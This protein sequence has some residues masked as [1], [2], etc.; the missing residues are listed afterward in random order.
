MQKGLI[1][2]FILIGILAVSL[3]GAGAY[4]YFY[5]HKQVAP[6]AG[7]YYREV[8]CIQAPCNPIL[9]CPQ[10]SPSPTQDETANWQTYTNNQ[11]GFSL[12][13]PA[14]WHVK[15]INDHPGAL[16]DLA[17]Y[18]NSDTGIRGGLFIGTH[19]EI[20]TY[21]KGLTLA[22]YIDQQIVKPYI[23]YSRS[24]DPAYT[25]SDIKISKLAIDGLPAVMISGIRG[26]TGMNGGLKEIMAPGESGSYIFVL[27]NG[28]LLVLH[29]EGNPNFPDT[30][31]FSIDEQILPTFK[32]TGQ[33]G[34]GTD[35][36]QVPDPVSSTPLTI[37]YKPQPGWNTYTD[38]VAKFSVQYGPRD[39][40]SSSEQGKEVF[41]LSCFDDPTRGELC[42][43]GF[44]ISVNSD[45]NGGSRREWLLNRIPDLKTYDLSYEEVV[46]SGVRSLIVFADDSGSTSNTYVLM[47]KNNKM[48]RLHYPGG[49]QSKDA[50][51]EILSTF[52]FNQ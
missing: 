26:G 27:K 28:Q 46:V 17:F 12:K 33:S 35:V 39:K 23:A 11:Y 19:I 48:Y 32:F 16:L 20:Y 50:V 31:L 7:C 22:D 24:F 34:S 41:S 8:Q 37:Q 14:D 44:N 15:E 21:T 3:V 52:K 2:I 38:T 5:S 1:P 49:S 40:I 13:Y 4:Y 36:S 18:A 47:P 25:G 29:W 51:K 30:N 43:Q 42:M 6:P 9:V 10:P 45:Y